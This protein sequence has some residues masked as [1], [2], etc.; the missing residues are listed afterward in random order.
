MTDKEF[1]RLRREDLIE[2]IYALQKSQA[3]LQEE[4]EKL[5]SQLA[6]RRLRLEQAGSIAQAALA[7][8]GVFDAAQQAADQY[9]AE[10]RQNN[11]QTKAICDRLLAD[12]QRKAREILQNAQDA[13]Q[14]TQE[15]AAVS[16]MGDAPELL[17]R[18]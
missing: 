5:Q 15:Q 8:N 17:A 14:Q 10:I 11:E 2:I 18:R 13:A 16:R 12:A 4:N 9:L 6:E 7:L 1:R 3:Q